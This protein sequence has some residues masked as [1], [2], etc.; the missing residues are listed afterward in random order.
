MTT[1]DLRVR[2]QAAWQTYGTRE[3]GDRIFKGLADAYTAPD[4]HY[5]NLAH[6]RDC[7]EAL[8]ACRG[9]AEDPDAV[10][11]ALWFHDAVY[12]THA[13]DNEEQ[14]A[15]WAAG[16]IGRGERAAMIHRLILA[17]KHGVN[18]P[19]DAD[20]CLISD[21]DLAI[22]GAAEARFRA[23]EDAIRREYEW[24]PDGVFRTRRA[25][26][27]QRFLQQDRIYRTPRFHE[28]YDK[29]ARFNLNASITRLKRNDG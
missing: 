28:K 11:I 7:L 27:L 29:A 18:N 3:A 14:S 20:T 17:T 5:H 2:W 13:A 4:R 6:I 26:I 24:V 12:D 21:I 10:E 8:D 22:L 9:D 23:Y 25:D 19:D 1:E 15:D 16:E